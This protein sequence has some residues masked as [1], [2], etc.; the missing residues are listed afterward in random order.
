VQYIGNP[1]EKQL[2]SQYTGN[3]QSKTMNVVLSIEFNNN[4]L[5]AKVLDAPIVLNPIQKDIFLL[6]GTM[7]YVH[8]DRNT[9][10][11]IISMHYKGLKFSKA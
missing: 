7:D 1:I 9:D 10:N 2:L 11:E 6:E 5:Q 3:Y 8:F 4:Q